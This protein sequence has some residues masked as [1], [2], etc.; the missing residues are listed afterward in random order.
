MSTT[1][2]SQTQRLQVPN[3]LGLPCVASRAVHFHDQAQLPSLQ[4]L[5]DQHGM[6]IVLAGASNVI[7]PPELLRPVV[8][9]RSQGIRLVRQTSEHWLVDVAAG[10]NWHAWVQH[11]LAQGWRGLENLAL[12]PGSVGAAP[13]QNIGAYG[14][15]VCERI[16]SVEIWDFEQKQS[17]WLSLAECEFGYRDSV[18]KQVR[19]RHWMV[20]TVRFALPHQWQPV[21]SYPDLKP[22]HDRYQSDPQTVSAQDVFEQVVAVRQ[23]KLPDPAVKPNVGSFFKNPVIDRAQHQTLSEAFSGLVS[24]PQAD[25]RFKLAAAWLIDQCGYKGKRLGPVAVHERQALVLINAGGAS[26]QDVLAAAQ[27]IVSDVDAKFGVKLEMEPVCF[28]T[29]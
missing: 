9:V 7:V 20:L 3:T 17:R 25:G 13:I 8:L 5:Y 18:F 1:F 15:E 29:D 23:A 16:D 19:G 2:S 21:L 24:Y 22:L 10:E 11:A 12:I 14:V 27:A 4:A 26:A 28:V 6:P